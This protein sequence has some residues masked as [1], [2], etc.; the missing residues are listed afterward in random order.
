MSNILYIRHAEPFNTFLK[1]DGAEKAFDY[2]PLVHQKSAWIKSIVDRIM[3]N[4]IPWWGDARQVPIIG[5]SSMAERTTMTLHEI[6]RILREKDAQ[7]SYTIWLP[8]SLFY[9][10]V[11]STIHTI[12]EHVNQL[13]ALYPMESMILVVWH[14]P[15]MKDLYL[16]HGY[17]EGAVFNSQGNIVDKIFHGD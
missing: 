13:Q 14:E 15:P 5:V 16:P 7:A 8:E 6:L 1:R 4:Q 9:G 3:G 11:R 10:G 17:C 12:R 2:K